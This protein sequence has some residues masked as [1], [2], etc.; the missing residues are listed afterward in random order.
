MKPLLYLYIYLFEE[1][2]EKLTC[3]GLIYI[4]YLEH[5]EIITP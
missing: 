5:E 1:E 3:V 2:L 4:F